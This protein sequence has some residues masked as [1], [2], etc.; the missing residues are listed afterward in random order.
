M[1]KEV[2]GK[3]S[4]FSGAV[5]GENV[6][7][8]PFNGEVATIVWKWRFSTWQPGHFS[9]VTIKLEDKDGGTKLSLV[10]TAVPEEE[11]ERTQKG[12]SG[13]LFDRLKAMLGGSV[14]G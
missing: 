3:F 2:G 11:Q 8:T 1:S 12:W 9:T 4:M 10:Q 13:L 7:L 14:M 5:E 6:A